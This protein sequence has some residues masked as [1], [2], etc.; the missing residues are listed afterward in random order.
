MKRSLVELIE[1]IRELKR[2]RNAVI[3][4]H[5]QLPEVH[6]IAHYVG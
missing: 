2:K 1:K 3:L 5:N 6:D 4:A